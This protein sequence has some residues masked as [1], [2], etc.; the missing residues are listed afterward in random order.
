MLLG[1]SLPAPAAA[2]LSQPCGVTC[3][4]VLGVTG[5]TFA[6]GA[7][8][9]YGRYTGG[10]SRPDR[11][12]GVLVTSFAAFTG[13]GLALSG[14]GERQERAVYG[15]GAGAIIGSVVWM[16]IERADDESDDGGELAALLIGAAAG[17]LVG[18]VYA[19]L[20]HDP[21]EDSGGASFSLSIPF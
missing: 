14:N 4:V 15:A 12:I 21:T 16:A 17:S 7:M 3:G 8:V 10:F 11:G 19:A 18:G 2:Q 20:T 9:A 1:S 6:T 5:V 13:A